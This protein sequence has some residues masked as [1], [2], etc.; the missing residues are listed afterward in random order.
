MVRKNDGTIYFDGPNPTIQSAAADCDINVIID[1]LKKGMDISHLVKQ[2]QGIYGDFT[3]FPDLRDAM[4]MVI[5]ANEMF[6]ALD[7]FLRKRFDNDPAKLVEFVDDPMNR[8]EAIRMGL[9]IAPVEAAKADL[10][11][12][13]SVSDVKPAVEAK[14]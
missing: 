6:L 3:Q 9:V 13:T 12:E 2:N 10:V 1:R 4:C 5:K 14:A 11:K 7:P 8:D